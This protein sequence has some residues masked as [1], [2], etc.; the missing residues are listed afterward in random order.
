MQ[1]PSLA[2]TSCAITLAIIALA[3]IVVYAISLM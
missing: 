2:R 1:S 3:C